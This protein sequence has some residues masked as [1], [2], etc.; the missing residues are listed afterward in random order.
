MFNSRYIKYFIII[1]VLVL[2]FC[3]STQVSFGL[4][5]DVVDSTNLAN[6]KSNTDTIKSDVSTIKTGLTTLYNYLY[7]SGNGIREGIQSLYNR[8]NQIYNVLTHS[9]LGL[10]ALSQYVYNIDQDMDTLNNSV[11]AVGGQVADVSSKLLNTNSYLSSLNSSAN[12]INTSVNSLAANI[13]QVNWHAHSNS[14]LYSSN[15]GN[16][17]YTTFNATNDLWIRISGSQIDNSLIKYNIP[18]AYNNNYLYDDVNIEFYLT[19]SLHQFYPEYYIIPNVES[20]DIIINPL[21]SQSGDFRYLFLHLTGTYNFSKMNNSTFSTYYLNLN[22]SDYYQV[23]QFLELNSLN[24][25]FNNFDGSFDVNVDVDVD[26]SDV[27]QA[28]ENLDL[29]NNTN[30][31]HIDIDLDPAD[32]IQITNAINKFGDLFDTGVSL[33][34]FITSLNLLDNFAWFTPATDSIVNPQIGGYKNLY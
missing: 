26:N 21:T 23:A 33:T 24:S 27:V 12:T 34:A 15:G 28:I 1:S 14:I 10:H 5:W 31:I 2:L 8:T 30:D 11:L 6:I 4:A 25:K 20:F 9:T 18:I 29:V 13:D 22:D 7:N 3:A 19:T 16:A 32:G 17:Y